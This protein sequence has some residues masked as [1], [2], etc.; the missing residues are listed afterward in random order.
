MKALVYLSLHRWL[1]SLKRIPKTPR[2]LFPILFFA[3]AL[4]LQLV[5]IVLAYR[6]IHHGQNSGTQLSGAWHRHYHAAPTAMPALPGMTLTDFTVGG[7]GAFI[8]GIRALLLLSLFTSVIVALNEGNLFFET[9]DIDFLFPAPFR[10]RSVLFIRMLAR[11]GALLFPVVYLPIAF[12]GPALAMEAGVSPFGLWPGMLGAWLFQVA[13]ANFAQA[14]IIARGDRED[15][16]SGQAERADRRRGR[17][18]LA[19]GIGLALLLVAGAA[20]VLPLLTSENTHGTHVCGRCC[21]SAM[22]A[23]PLPSS[24]LSPGLPTCFASPSRAGPG[25]QRRDWQDSRC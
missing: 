23:S 10:R 19:L 20:Y 21:A 17:L 6:G 22:G 16:D 11:Y 3:G 14:A 7:P 15:E 5:P 1:N 2:L 4:L 25:W 12:G 8:L 18:R 9:S 24:R 13:A